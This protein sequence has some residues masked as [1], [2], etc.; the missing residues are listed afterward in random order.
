MPTTGDIDGLA[1]DDVLVCGAGASGLSSAALLAE[2]G[3]RCRVLERTPH[4]AASWRARYDGLRLNT[5]GWMST[6]PGYHVGRRGRH[7]PSR[8]EWVN[9]L[10]RYAERHHLRIEFDTEALR[11]DRDDGRWR[12]ETSRE[13]LASGRV[14]VATGY[15]RI[16][17]MPDW[18]GRETYTRELIHSADFRNAGPYRGRD[19]LIV[20]P[21]VTGSELAHFVS[22]GG[23][24]RTRVAVRTPPNITRRCR[25][26]VPLNPAA[27]V[28]NRLPAAIGDRAAALSQRIMFGD[29]TPYGLPRPEMGLVSTNRKRHQ[30]PVVDDGFVD[31]VKRGEIEIVAS[32]EGFDRDDVIL[33]DGGRIQPDAV[34]AATGY[35]RG[36]ESLVGHLGV[37][38]DRGVPIFQGAAAHPGAPGLHFVGYETRLYGQLRGIRL[39][40]RSLARALRSSG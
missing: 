6:L 22:A 11:I 33:A 20:G 2:A 25:F 8:D 7:F 9:Y 5:L 21:N 36:L 38:D 17:S 19:V 18:P 16:P 26:G 30:G 15:D 39:E 14:V 1:M 40:A 23:A 34:I 31:A 10:E 12:V 24:A 37:L 32:V 13:V 29:L 3:L 28:L 4:V 35:K 27:V